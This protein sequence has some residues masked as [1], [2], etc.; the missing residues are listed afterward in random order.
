MLK[1]LFVYFSYRDR[2]YIITLRLK[3]SGV[4]VQHIARM[5]E[6]IPFERFHCVRCVNYCSFTKAMYQRIVLFKRSKKS[7]QQP[8]S[9]FYIYIYIDICFSL[10]VFVFC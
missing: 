7:P 4:S 2:L 10:F 3:R 9:I 6:T 1:R 5:E 8:M